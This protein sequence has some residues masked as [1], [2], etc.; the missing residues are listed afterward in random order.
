VFPPLEA[1]VAVLAVLLAALGQILNLVREVFM[2]AAAQAVHR[3]LLVTGE[4]PAVKAR[5][6]LC[7]PEHQD[8]F[9]QLTWEAHN[10]SVY[11]S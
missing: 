8:N 2:A 4:V 7:G 3:G 11:S 1:V 6:G 10:E 5:F 9:Q